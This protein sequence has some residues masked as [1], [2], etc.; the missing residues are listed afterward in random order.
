MAIKNYN[1]FPESGEILVR[2]NGAIVEI[3]K[4]ESVEEIWRNEREVI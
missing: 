2:E 3:R 1:S 4:R